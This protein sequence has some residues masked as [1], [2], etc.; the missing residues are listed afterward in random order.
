[1]AEV[2][3]TAVTA[4]EAEAVRAEAAVLTDAD[5]LSTGFNQSAH[6]G[7]YSR[8]KA[9]RLRRSFVCMDVFAWVNS[10]CCASA[11]V[12]LALS[13]MFSNRFQFF[14]TSRVDPYADPVGRYH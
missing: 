5:S 10:A 12:C 4:A 3:P 8:S 11:I 6:S 7:P 14:A 1:M 2:S 13:S 9:P